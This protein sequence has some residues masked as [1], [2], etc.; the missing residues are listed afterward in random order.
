M[1]LLVLGTAAARAAAPLTMNLAADL[2][3]YH[4]AQPATFLAARLPAQ[5]KA[6]QEQAARWAWTGRAIQILEARGDAASLAAAAMLQAGGA[7]DAPD[8]AG[9]A[10]V[11]ARRA[12]DADPDN[13]AAGWLWLRLCEQSP[14]CDVAETAT[15]LRW[16]DPDNA[17]NW[18]PTLARAQR[19]H[20]AQ[21]ID[22]VLAEMA[23]GR[24]IRFYWNPTLVM[25]LDALRAASIA[26]A[27]QAAAER[28]RLQIV[29]GWAAGLLVP[30]LHPLLEACHD[31]AATFV[32]HESC[33]RIVLL[34]QHADTVVAQ[35]AGFAIQRRLHPPDS[36]EARSAAEHR[37]AL[38]ERV[39]REAKLETAFLPWV[40]NRIATHRIALMRRYEREEDCIDAVLAERGG[41]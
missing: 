16:L 25:V 3:A 22:R 33:N 30:S 28:K 13:H 5:P 24:R 21:Q 32:R 37:H 27:P 29:T 10:T 20:N 19:E 2:P 4:A 41:R 40:R 8:A 14:G 6:A 35:L 12:A 36:A 18:L 15:T 7:H 9:R 26:P 38:E 1:L 17:A 11:L 34:L 23:Q 31:A 39:Q